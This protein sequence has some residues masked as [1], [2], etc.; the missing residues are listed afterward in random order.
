M[1]RFITLLSLL[2]FMALF[3]SCAQSVKQNG[4]INLDGRKIVSRAVQYSMEKSRA[5]ETGDD[6]E[7][8]TS[9]MEEALKAAL[10]FKATLSMEIK[11]ADNSYH[12][13]AEEDYNVDY[14]SGAALEKKTITFTDVPVGIKAT[15]TA[16]I[17]TKLTIKDQTA[18][19]KL[20]ELMDMPAEL[21]DLADD[22]LIENLSTELNWGYTLYGKSELTVH[23][24]ENPVTMKMSSDPKIIEGG[25]EGGDDESIEITGSV[26]TELPQTLTIKINS[27]KTA[28]KF[29]LNKGDLVFMLLDEEGNDIAAA[30]ETT[31]GANWEYKLYYGNT[32]IPETSANSETYFSYAPGKIVLE[33][34]PVSGNYHLYVQAK[35]IASGYENC[36]MVSATFEIEVPNTTY[37]E[38]AAGNV[39]DASGVVTDDFNNLINSITT[40]AY[41]K[42]SGEISAGYS[43]IMGLF[44][45]IKDS[46]STVQ[47]LIDFDF[48]ETTTTNSEKFAVG[49]EFQNCSKLRSIILPDDLTQIG[50]TAFTGCTNLEKIVFGSSLSAITS[51]GTQGV[52]GSCSKLASVV[53]PSTAP[54]TMI[55]ALAFENDTS[56]KTLSLPA[57]FVALGCNALGSI[58]NL[59][60]ADE[61]G[62]WYYTN[63]F[64]DWS[65]W[66]SSSMEPP[67]VTSDS[68]SHGLLSE[69]KDPNGQSISGF[70]ENGTVAE[71]LLFAAKNTG[72]YFYCVK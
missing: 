20:F 18:L 10:D 39:L 43:G 53:I 22:L 36:D 60:L 55:G 61:S 5:P 46:I 31:A 37:Y 44:M 62:T 13:S 69:L 64:N 7:E 56:L 9:E 48:S 50:Y 72:Y 15:I 12:D 29:F 3:I 66:C 68:T 19:T 65:S 14:Y 38:F 71:K 32:E 33:N 21:A 41:I 34:L 24:G 17:T 35:P 45:P 52:L 1:R 40:D 27:E 63:G 58:E 59:V 25:E 42:I 8:I 49:A 54:L 30:N 6:K 28:S 57:S 16:K 67:T 11:S 4:S 2:V 26:E 51:D 23:E 70:P 47:Y